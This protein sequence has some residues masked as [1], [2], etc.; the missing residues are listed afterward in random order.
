[1]KFATIKRN[2]LKEAAL[3]R[4]DG[5]VPL[6][7]GLFSLI[8]DGRL[9][10]AETHATGEIVPFGEVEYGPLYRRP[11][12]IWGIGLNYTEHAEDLNENAP[13]EEPAS[14]MRPDT[15]IIGSGDEIRLPHQS[16]RITGE[17]ELA[18]IIGR[19]AKDVSVEE[20]WSAIAGFTT[21]IDMT[22]EE[23]LSQEPAL[24]DPRQEL[25]HL[26]LVRA[27]PLDAG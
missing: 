25:R 27:A 11:R 23:H 7:V 1:M 2:G 3:V 16:E 17:V 14:F 20:A 15:T 8:S 24:P 6:G 19:E 21:V 9:A 4:K 10:E 13:S 12:K 22:A 26:L 5:V 18:V